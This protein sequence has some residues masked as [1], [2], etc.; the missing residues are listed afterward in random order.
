VVFDCD[1]IVVDSEPLAE[2][3]LREVLAV[4]GHELAPD[5][6]ASLRGRS[7]AQIYAYF[8]GKVGARLPDATAFQVE[9]HRRLHAV[10]ATS[11]R[12]FPDS[13]ALARE[14]RRKRV[15]FA[16]ATNSAR[17]NLT[18]K[19][20]LTGLVDLFPVSVS[21][22]DVGR[23]KP[24][25]DLYLAAADRL[26][27]RP[28]ECMAIEDTPTGSSAARAAGMY[29]VVVEREPTNGR[30]PGLQADLVLPSVDPAI[31]TERLGPYAT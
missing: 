16:V 4:Y 6:A 21:V 7:A 17:A 3:V 25:P 28:S 31:L 14:L 19:L 29:V 10:W 12:A 2:S 24:A 11:L 18:R 15:P 27:L 1:G 9:V 8:A 23:P 13:V 5:E 30:P 20:R 22:D 26:R